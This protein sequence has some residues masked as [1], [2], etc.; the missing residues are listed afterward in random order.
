M[1]TKSGQGYHAND[2]WYQDLRS[3]YEDVERKAAVALELEKYVA[4]A[5]DAFDLAAILAWYSHVPG[6]W[7][8]VVAEWEDGIIRVWRAGAPRLR[9]RDAGSRRELF[10]CFSALYAA[11]LRH[12]SRK[13]RWYPW[14]LWFRGFG[15]T[16]PRWLIARNAHRARRQVLGLEAR[17]DTP[18]SELQA[19]SP[20]MPDSGREETQHARN[21]AT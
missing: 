18:A 20:T 1:S 16:W 4:R 21:R 3:Q 9:W 7:Y 8:A 10:E 12:H 11:A 6:L 15:V 5:Y 13:R 2:K 17:P 19:R 14:G